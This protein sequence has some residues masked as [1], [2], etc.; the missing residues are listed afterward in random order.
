MDGSRKASNHYEHFRSNGSRLLGRKR[1]RT[2]RD[3]GGLWTRFDPAKLATPKAF[4]RTPDD[5]HAFY[6]M[7][8]RNVLEARPNAAHYALARLDSELAK[9]GGSLFL[10]TQNVDDL[11]ERAGTQRV[12]HMHGELL[13][14]RCG[15][16]KATMR[17]ERDLSR[18][19]VCPS[20]GAE[21]GLRP[22]VV[23]F[24]EMPLHLEAIQDALSAA[25][26]F[27]A[28]GTSGSVY[29]AAGF[30]ATARKRGIPTCEL[31]MEPS[32]NAHLVTEAHHGP[33]TEVVPAW[34]ERVLSER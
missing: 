3:K 21:G 24:G 34:M 26:A 1:H 14:A 17:W 10:C 13:K 15:R 4:A 9:R 12:V 28:I 19:D 27:A 6:N 33:A 23:W 20:C 31:N 16:C 22:D 7:R 8:R 32:D 2:F 29:P 30:V 11:H 18:Q 25:D 5:V